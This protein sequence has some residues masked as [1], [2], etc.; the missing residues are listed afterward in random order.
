MKTKRRHIEIYFIL[1]LA[2]LVLILP[3]GRDKIHS[4]AGT[5]ENNS[6]GM[7]SI[8]PGKTNLFAKVVK[9]SLGWRIVSIDS[10]NSVYFTGNVT[11]VQY[12]FLL[13]D[14]SINQY[15]NINNKDQFTSKYFRYQ[16]NRQY[17]SADFFWFP[18]TLDGINKTYTVQVTATA[19]SN[20][21]S[22]NY[23][24]YKAKT[25]FGLNIVYINSASALSVSGSDVFGLF[26]DSL[27]R[28]QNANTGRVSGNGNFELVPEKEYIR[29]LNMQKWS[30]TIYAYN[31]N[32]FKDL[33]HKPEMY[34]KNEPS[35][36]G[37]EIRMDVFADKLVLT[38]K[39]PNSGRTIVTIKV[40]RKS[41]DAAKTLTFN[42]SPAPLEMPIFD[43]IMY[44]GRTY[45]IEPKLPL[46]AQDMKAFLRD[47]NNTRAGSNSG[48]R[49]S[50]TPNLSDTG[51]TMTLERYIDNNLIGEKFQ[52]HIKSYPNPEIIEIQSESNGD[53]RVKTRTY[54]FVG[55]D[56]NYIID[57]EIRGNASYKEIYGK[58]DDDKD[59]LTH[60]QVFRFR[61]RNQKQAFNFSISAVD[62]NG[63]RSVFKNYNGN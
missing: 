26:L 58:F 6:N 28:I 56:N 1:Y 18:P 61:P 45:Y 53:V 39:S 47:G 17:N 51:K 27:K 3:N 62:K 34:F 33:Q 57:F 21:P 25:Q 24:T 49:F 10:T 29:T 40:T 11:D 31:I 8:A 48:E 19:R 36:N 2:A 50:F 4:G 42:I 63:K 37:G 9:D 44:P 60:I 46:L 22:D 5:N 59:K 13:Q 12:E 14:N 32:L 15:I 41:D 7:F 35:N 20:N 55:S 54:G 23:Q 38:G 30:N 16:E 52:I 43:R